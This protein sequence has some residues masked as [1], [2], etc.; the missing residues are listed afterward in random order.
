[1]C[2]WLSHIFFFNFVLQRWLWSKTCCHRLAPEDYGLPPNPMATSDSK[3]SPNGMAGNADLAANSSP[4]SSMLE[5]SNSE[6]AKDYEVSLATISISHSY[7]LLSL[8]LFCFSSF[9]LVSLFSIWI[10][11]IYFTFN[12]FVQGS[13]S[14]GPIQDLVL[15]WLDGD[16]GGSNQYY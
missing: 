5:G 4:L 14:C 7:H 1:M 8:F 15:Y 10:I 3:G 16:W 13:G 9:L 2:P 12:I 11:F 6:V